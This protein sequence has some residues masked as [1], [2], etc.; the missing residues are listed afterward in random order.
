MAEVPEDSKKRKRGEDMSK[1]LIEHNSKL[2]SYI[3][4]LEF[5]LIETTKK[6]YKSKVVFKNYIGQLAEALDRA[7]YTV[8]TLPLKRMEPEDNIDLDNLLKEIEQNRKVQ[9]E[10]ES[11]KKKMGRP[12]KETKAENQV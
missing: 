7:G 12:K 4:R 5:M 1:E 11:K 8:P 10:M 2:A 6:Y 3:H 9:E